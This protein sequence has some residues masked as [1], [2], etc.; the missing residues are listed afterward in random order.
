M[1]FQVEYGKIGLQ[2]NEKKSDVFILLSQ[3]FMKN[4]QENGQAKTTTDKQIYNKQTESK[5][6]TNW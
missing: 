6:E 1:Q 5:P 4:I 2:F 3:I